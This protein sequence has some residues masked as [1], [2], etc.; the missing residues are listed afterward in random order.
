M[1][2]GKVNNVKKKLLE[3]FFFIFLGGK[4]KILTIYCQNEG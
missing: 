1:N 4:A 3:V 2:V